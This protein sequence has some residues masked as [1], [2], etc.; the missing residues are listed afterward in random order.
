MTYGKQGIWL[1]LLVAALGLTCAPKDDG[2]RDVAS[3]D[4]DRPGKRPSFA[5]KD[6]KK[7]VEAA[8]T[9]IKGRDLVPAQGFWTIFHAILGMGFDTELVVGKNG[10]RVK[11]IDYVADGK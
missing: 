4:K 1:A 8:L 7:T 10:Q 6:L 9:D 5:D 11:A 2:P 3:T